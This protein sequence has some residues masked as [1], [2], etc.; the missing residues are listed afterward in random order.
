MLHEG[1]AEAVGHGDGTSFAQ[2]FPAAHAS[3]G[4]HTRNLLDARDDSADAVNDADITV[5][6]TAEQLQAVIIAGALDI[7]LRGHVDLTGLP[8]AQSTGDLELQYFATALGGVRASTRSI[9]V[10]ASPHCPCLIS[11]ISYQKNHCQ[12]LLT[13]LCELRQRRGED[14][15]EPES[16]WRSTGA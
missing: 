2:M 9:Q 1:Q 12:S 4:W 10:Q 8:L 16:I 14:C 13:P 3:P 6:T 5:V 7:Q 15:C 11:S